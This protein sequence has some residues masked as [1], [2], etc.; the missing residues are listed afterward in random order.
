MDGLDKNITEMREAMKDSLAERSDATKTF[1][2]LSDS[3]S[4][5]IQMELEEK[6]LAMEE[7]RLALEEKKLQLAQMMEKQ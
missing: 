2:K 1:A 6:K 4:A 5:L 7:R 3:I